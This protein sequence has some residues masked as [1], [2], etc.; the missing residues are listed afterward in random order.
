MKLEQ[1]KKRSKCRAGILSDIR[2]L[3]EKVAAIRF[4]GHSQSARYV[5]A[6]TLPSASGIVP[7]RLV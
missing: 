5:S 1:E 7:E 4:G 2:S 3:P 6:M